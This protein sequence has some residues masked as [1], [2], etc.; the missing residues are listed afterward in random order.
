MQINGIEITQELAYRGRYYVQRRSVGGVGHY[1]VVDR[2]T[3]ETILKNA[4]QA[5]AQATAEELNLEFKRLVI[6]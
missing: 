6:Q 3:C 1:N 4:R 5:V 2:F